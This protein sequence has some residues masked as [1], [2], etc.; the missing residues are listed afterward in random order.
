MPKEMGYT[1]EVPEYRLT[2]RPHGVGWICLIYDRSSGSYV[3]P[4]DHVEP[5]LDA[6]KLWACRYASHLAALHIEQAVQDPCEE[7]LTLWKEVL[8]DSN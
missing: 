2:V 5:T 6:A 4:I 7:M 1:I 8:L 3:Q